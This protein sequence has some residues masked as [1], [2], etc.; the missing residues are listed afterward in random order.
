MDN[1]HILYWTSLEGL[2]AVKTWEDEYHEGDGFPLS[3][4]VADGHVFKN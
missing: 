3:S 2:G 1:L 4:Q